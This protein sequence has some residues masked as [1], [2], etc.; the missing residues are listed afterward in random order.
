MPF[1]THLRPPIDNCRYQKLAIDDS[2]EARKLNH[3]HSAVSIKILHQGSNDTRYSHLLVATESWYR[4]SKMTAVNSNLFKQLMS[5][6]WQ[7]KIFLSNSTKISQKYIALLAK[8]ESLAT[9][10]DKKKLLIGFSKALQNGRIDAHTFGNAVNIDPK[11]LYSSSCIQYIWRKNFNIIPPKSLKQFFFNKRNAYFP[12]EKQKDL[13][14]ILK[15][16]HLPLFFVANNSKQIV[17]AEPASQVIEKGGLLHAMS[18]WYLDSFVWQKDNGGVYEGWFFV[19][20]KDA[21]EYKDFITSKYTRSHDQ[22]GLRLFAGGMS[23]YYSLN[24]LAPPRTEFRICP[25]LEEVGQLITNN[26]Y[27]R[28]VIFDSR[29]KYGKSYFQGQPIYF[30]EPFAVKYK[31]SKSIGQY[32]YTRKEEN[33]ERQYQAVFLNKDVA[34]EA[35]KQFRSNR[36]KHSIPENP[37]LRVYNL[38]DFLKDEENRSKTRDNTFLLVPGLDTYQA[39][40]ASNVDSALFKLN[41][42]DNLLSYLRNSQLWSRRLV[43]SLISRQPPA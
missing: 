22:H 9:K 29:Q 41:N 27:R 6:Y 23:F 3:S 15:N 24:R 26:S 19:N 11:Q 38:E 7:Q 33:V 14:Q 1:T 13:L 25:D 39:F 10:N 37:K 16:N 32:Y 42:S 5:N 2:F 36:P 21:E 34:L 30:I 8:Q 18:Q 35:W 28:N 40:I 31:G 17:M 20:P 12:S 43:G 4:F